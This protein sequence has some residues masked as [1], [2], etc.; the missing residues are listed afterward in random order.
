MP[1]PVKKFR[2]KPIVIEAMQFN[3]FE[4]YLAISE[5]MK[6]AGDTWALAGEIGYSTPEMYINTLEGR[7]SAQP[8]DWIIRGVK[9][10]FYPCKPNIFEA[11]Y[12][13]A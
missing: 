7:M 4:D 13:P 5:W 9:G 2:K 10:E 11:T 8:S 12:E 3:G 1:E 6:A